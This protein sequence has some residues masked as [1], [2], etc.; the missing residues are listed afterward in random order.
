MGK[1]RSTKMKNRY[2]DV[3]ITENPS[4]CDSVKK[5]KNQIIINLE[6]V[7][8]LVNEAGYTLIEIYGDNKFADL[9]LICNNDH[10]FNM[11]YL[12]FKI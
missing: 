12:N 1:E 2:R 11:K 9:S 3:F 8:K 5:K 6:S 4:K 7:S 10:N